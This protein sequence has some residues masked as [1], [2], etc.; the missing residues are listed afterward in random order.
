MICFNICVSIFGFQK[1]EKEQEL[2]AKGVGGYTT[3]PPHGGET[4]NRVR[5]TA[6]KARKHQGLKVILINYKRSLNAV[7]K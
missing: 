2:R 7:G 3:T 4:L 5:A 1:Q 6:F